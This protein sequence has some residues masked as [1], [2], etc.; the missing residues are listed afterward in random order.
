[1][2][3]QLA[4]RVG[5]VVPSVEIA[6]KL[7]I[8]WDGTIADDGAGGEGVSI[9]GFADHL[10]PANQ[11]GRVVFGESSIAIAGAVIDGSVT[12]LKTDANGKLIPVA[13]GTDVVAARLKPGETATAADQQIE[14]FPVRN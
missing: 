14:V 2:S 13:A 3:Q 11:A 9:M 1:M 5:T 4:T 7:A 10:I 6:A 8:A 12:G